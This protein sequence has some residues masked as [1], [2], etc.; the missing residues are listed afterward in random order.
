MRRCNDTDDD[1]CESVVDPCVF[2]TDSVG[3]IVEDEMRFKATF[4]KKKK[5]QHNF[6]RVY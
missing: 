6:D 5:V 2:R 4:Q 1:V 3:W